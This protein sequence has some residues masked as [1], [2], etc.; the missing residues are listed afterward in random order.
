LPQIARLCLLSTFLEDGL[1][2]LIKFNSQSNSI[3]RKWGAPYTIANIF[4]IFNLVSQI[5]PCVL[6]LRRKYI[7]IAVYLLFANIALKVPEFKAN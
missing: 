7:N 6:I 1:R 4:V 3:A 2:I 5:I